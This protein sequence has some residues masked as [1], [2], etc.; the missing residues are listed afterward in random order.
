MV[1][2]G[3]FVDKAK[4]AEWASLFSCENM[5]EE[6]F[7]TIAKA[8]MQFDPTG[9]PG[10]I[11][12][13]SL[14]P[15]YIALRDVVVEAWKGDKTD[16]RSRNDYK[17]KIDMAVGLALYGFLRKHGFN[18]VYAETDDWWRFVSIKLCPDLTY[19]RY[20]R[21]GEVRIN[22]KRFYDHPRRIWLKTLWWYVHL[23]WQGSV[24]ATKAVLAEM[25]TD[26]ISQIIERPGRGYRPEVSRVIAAKCAAESAWCGAKPFQKVMA[27]NSVYCATF[28]PTLFAGGVEGYADRIFSETKEWMGR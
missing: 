18:E 1:F 16:V 12:W 9:G 6:R 23:C 28:E 11:D 7:S 27:R 22:R 24:E 4:A 26:A 20:P 5:T 3:N 17:Y 21:E 19:Q 2:D 13:G 14:D 8:W 25:G 10:A 15:D